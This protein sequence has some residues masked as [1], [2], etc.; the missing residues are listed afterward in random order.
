MRQAGLAPAGV[1]AALQSAAADEG[2]R[3]DSFAPF[4]ER[5]PRLLAADERLTFD[6]YVRHGLGDLIGRFVAVA[7]GEWMTVSYAF[8]STGAEVAGLE[9]IVAGSGGGRDAHGT[10]ARQP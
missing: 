4:I 10:A 3:R 7:D 9:A 5:L 6:G 2:F 8:P 1:A